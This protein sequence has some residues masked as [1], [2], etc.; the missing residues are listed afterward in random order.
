VDYDDILTISTPEGVDLHLTLAGPASRFVSALVDILI[1]FVLLVC[2]A[3]VLGTVGSS[4]PRGGTLVLIWFVLSFAVITFYDVFFEVFNSGRTPGKLINGLRVVRVEGHPVTFVTS[5][6]RNIIRPIDFLPS[7]YLLGAVVIL[8][9]RKN[10]R[11]GDF[12]AGTIV[13]RDGSAGW[14]RRSSRVA[15]TAPETRDVA[16]PATHGSWDTS[17]ITAEEFAAVRQF[18]AR[19]YEIQHAARV[20]LARTLAERLRPK[21]T[22]APPELRGE[23]FLTALVAA[24]LERSA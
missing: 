15:A 11:V 17:R 16:A 24:K 9:T 22:G 18:L 1:Q 8:A 7:A 2:A 10:Q 5:A 19:R 13:V 4:E 12:V 14:R 21:V 3:V 20:D 23:Q 6:I